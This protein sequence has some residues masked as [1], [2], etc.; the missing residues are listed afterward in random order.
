MF[1]LSEERERIKI[2]G[3]VLNGDCAGIIFEEN[4]VA[5]VVM[6]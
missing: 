6:K 4:V 5:T 2:I 1:K 3:G